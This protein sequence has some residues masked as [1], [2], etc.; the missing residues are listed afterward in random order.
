MSEQGK[1][2]CMRTG[3][4]LI[5]SVAIFSA[6]IFRFGKENRGQILNYPGNPEI[7]RQE[8]PKADNKP[9]FEDDYNKAISHDERNV[10]VIFSA[11]WCRY[12]NILKNEMPSMNLEGYV[13]CV[14]DTTNNNGIKDK[15][16][17]SALPTSIV[18]N[19]GKEASRIVGYSQKKYKEWIEANRRP[20]K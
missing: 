12:C 4:V 11:D 1:E 10:L 7:K 8:R 14:V 16:G 13:V 3:M 18:M 5:L 19:N 20:S 17:V 15:N 9:I 2:V 6:I